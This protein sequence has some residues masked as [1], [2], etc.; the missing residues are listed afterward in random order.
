MN[1]AVVLKWQ[2]SLLIM[3]NNRRQMEVPIL[4]ED[5]DDW[6]NDEQE[7]AY[8]KLQQ[9]KQDFGSKP[10]KLYINRNEELQSYIMW[11]ARMENLPYE[12]TDKETKLC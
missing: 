6:G 5:I 7:K 10:T 1:M 12:L 2:L 9:L 4:D 8:D 3:M 11:F